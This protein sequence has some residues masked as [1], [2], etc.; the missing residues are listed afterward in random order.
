MPTWSVHSA[1]AHS[2][3]HKSSTGLLSPASD[4]LIPAS[5]SSTAKSANIFLR[6]ASDLSNRKQTNGMGSPNAPVF[7]QIF[8]WSTES[9][10]RSVDPNLQ[11]LRSQPCKYSPAECNRSVNQADWNHLLR[12]RTQAMLTMPEF[13]RA[14]S[15]NSELRSHHFSPHWTWKIFEQDRR[16][17]FV[18]VLTHWL[19]LFPMM[20]MLFYS[21]RHLDKLYEFCTSSSL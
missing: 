4:L 12:L 13:L 1:G 8:H 17:F 7:V 16:G 20:R 19:P 3:T 6:T 9:N 14:S 5:V 15:H 10:L 21:Q 18:F 11:Q 2:A